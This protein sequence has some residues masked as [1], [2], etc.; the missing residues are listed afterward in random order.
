MTFLRF[1]SFSSSLEKIEPALEAAQRLPA[2][3]DA[4]AIDKRRSIEEVFNS[5]SLS[6]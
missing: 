6:F 3:K 1:L 2:S 5:L 4:L